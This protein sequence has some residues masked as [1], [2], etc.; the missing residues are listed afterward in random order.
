[1]NIQKGF[2]FVKNDLKINMLKTKN[3]VK[4]GAIAITQV[5]IQLLQIAYLISSKVY[6]K[7]FQQFLQ[8]I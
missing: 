7:K 4:L 8:S 1:M 5:N 6:V 3:I 2:I